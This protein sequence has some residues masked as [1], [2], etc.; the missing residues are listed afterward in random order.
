MPVLGKITIPLQL[1]GREYPCEFHAMQNLAYDAILGR[2]FLQ[3]N[4]A[5]IDLVD[6]TLSFKGAR[7][8]GKQSTNTTT[9]PVMGTFLTRHKKLKEK[10]TAAIPV[11][12][13]LSRTTI[14]SK[15]VHCSVKNKEMSLHCSLLILMIIILYLLTSATCTVHTKDST[16]PIIQ[17]MPKSS[18]PET[19][20]F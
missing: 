6:S 4:G 8:L 9:V 18:V 5:L 15:L 16:T 12:S 11:Y 19:S 14:E 7:H 20:N 10:L 17:E 3:E 2:D 1:N 13:A